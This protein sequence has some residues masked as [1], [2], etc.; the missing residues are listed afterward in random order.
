M[1]DIK[2]NDMTCMNCVNKI[3]MKLNVNNIN[4]NIDLKNHTVQVED[5][6][7]SKA[8]ELIKEVGYNPEV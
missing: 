4:S 2:V 1:K 8:V 5:T 3:T 6:D 7:L